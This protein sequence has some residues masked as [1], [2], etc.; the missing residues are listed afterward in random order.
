MPHAYRCDMTVLTTE[1]SKT[2]SMVVGHTPRAANV[3]AITASCSTS[4]SMAPACVQQAVVCLVTRTVRT[5]KHLAHTP[6]PFHP[7]EPECHAS[8]SC[9]K[10]STGT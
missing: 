9:S 4:T 2:F 8:D 3:D 10:R 5:H 7:E 1:G 6:H